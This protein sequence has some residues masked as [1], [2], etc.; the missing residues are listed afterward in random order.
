MYLVC[1]TDIRQSLATP[2][3]TEKPPSLS[4]LLS[5]MTNSLT[6][7]LKLILSSLKVS[8]VGYLVSA[9]LY[10]QTKTANGSIGKDILFDI[11]KLFRNTFDY[12][13]NER[14][15]VTAL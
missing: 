11:N 10:L 6:N 3:G 15:L 2:S 8:T 9:P 5:T 13:K 14:R 12:K 7:Q 4:E 1:L